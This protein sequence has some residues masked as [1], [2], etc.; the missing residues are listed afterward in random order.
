[1]VKVRAHTCYLGN[2]G[3]S[4]HARHF[5]RE[6]S[7]HVEL[8]VR[9]FTWDDNPTY[10]NET[11]FSIVDKITLGYRN[12]YL[13]DF[14]IT[15]SFPKYPW[16]LS[17][18]FIPDVDIVL[19]DQNHD[20]FYEQYTAPIK[21]AYTVWESTLLD[22]QFFN[23]LLKFDYLWVVSEWHR[24]VVIKQGYPSDR[25]FVVNEGVTLNNRVEKDIDEYADGRFKFLFFGRWEYRKS[26]TEIIQS[27][28][29]AFPNNEPVDLILSA[30]NPYSVDGM[31]STEQR[32]NHWGFSDPRIKVKSFVD[33]TE[34]EEYIH[35]GNVLISCAR[36]EGWNIPLIEAM[37]CGTPSIYSDWGAQL[38]FAKGKGNPVK[39]KGELPAA[40]G[41]ELG[42]TEF[43]PGLYSEPDYR[44]LQEVLKDCYQN[45]DEKKT[46]ALQESS[47][48]QKKF[49]WEVVTK[50][51][52]TTLQSHIKNKQNG[53]S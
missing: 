51:A 42:L 49:S 33:R 50:Q 19:V 44:H 15:R 3:F 1:M 52:M 22:E 2:T 7:K 20:Y 18:D 35:R 26:V 11:D 16:K 31:K 47:D 28:L 43:V 39:I 21:I 13:A 46:K 38:E 30:D 45:Y 32:L 5:F 53:K 8:R 40:L 25:V 4:A 10:L 9:N 24:S 34:Y 48:I 6:L 23:Q 27:F 29:K 37:A 41:K 14:P 12:G 17:G 36:S